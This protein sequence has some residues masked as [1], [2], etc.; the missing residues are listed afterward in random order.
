MSLNKN[1]L[2]KKYY[3]IISYYPEDINNSAFDKEE[4]K[5][6]AFSELYT[7][8]QAIIRTLSACEVGGRILRSNELVDLLYVAYNRDESEVYGIEKAL[9]AGY[10]ELYTTAPDVLDKRMKELNIKIEQQAMELANQKVIQARSKKQQELDRRQER[11]EEL[12]RQR[13]EMILEQN[14]QYIGEK[15]AKRAQKLIEEDTKEMGGN[16]DDEQEK[17]P[18]TRR[19]R[20]TTTDASK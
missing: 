16:E 8:A 4:I 17:K 3:I 11:F 18:K 19:T 1:V 2:N 5:S 7:K 15:T 6:L 20:K 14:K 13:A 9:R 12:I 10:E